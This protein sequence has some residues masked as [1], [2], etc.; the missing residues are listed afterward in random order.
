VNDNPYDFTGEELDAFGKRLTTEREALLKAAQAMLAELCATRFQAQPGA[1]VA[2]QT[3]FDAATAYLLIGCPLHGQTIILEMVIERAGHPPASLP[4]IL[5]TPLHGEVGMRILDVPVTPG[6]WNAAGELMDRA[7]LEVQLRQER[8][9]RA[10]LLWAALH[11]MVQSSWKR[12]HAQKL[13]LQFSGAEQGADELTYHF[14]FETESD[15]PLTGTGAITCGA[16]PAGHSG[17]LEVRIDLATDAGDE[18][19]SDAWQHGLADR[20]GQLFRDTVMLERRREAIRLGA[21]PAYAASSMR[22]AAWLVTQG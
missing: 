2:S 8:D 18:V 6:L 12:G 13:S 15:D 17:Q 5:R 10:Q 7:M 22:E 21:D 1:Y 4:A 20:I 16:G 14:R 3:R 9:E 11:S 19:F